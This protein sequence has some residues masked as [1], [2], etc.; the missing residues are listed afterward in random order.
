[1]AA[2]DLTG[3][4]FHKLTALYP[5]GEKSEHGKNAVWMCI[6]ECGNYTV[7]NTGQL[8]C[9][10]KKSCGCAIIDH[11][12]S[13]NYIHGG[14]KDRLYYVWMD[15]RRR[16]RDPKSKEYKNYGGRGISVCPEW[17]NSYEA[18]KEWALKNGYDSMAKRSQCTLDRINV[19][20]DYRP[21]N[22]RWV[23]MVL[24]CNNKRNSIFLTYNGTEKTA[25][26]WGKEYGI[27]GRTI[28]RRIRSGWSI[29]KA[30]TQPPRQAK[31]IQTGNR[32]RCI[33]EH[34]K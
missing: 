30:I 31:R 32:C 7:A 11:A 2:L 19:D 9:G 3:H 23:D 14:R 29:E 17:D 1:M 5:T 16:C 28:M 26:E 34:V 8:R 10:T 13:L 21:E 20:G 12:R 27:S 15:M 6:C 4:K 24:Q 25:A 33:L 22:C 18:F